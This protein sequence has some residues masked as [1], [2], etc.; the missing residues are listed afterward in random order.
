MK[1]IALNPSFG[2]G[3]SRS[4]SVC[5]FDANGNLISSAEIKA[6]SFDELLQKIEERE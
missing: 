5:E 2:F 1:I 6:G 4:A 3:E